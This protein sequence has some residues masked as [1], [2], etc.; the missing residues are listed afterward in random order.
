MLGGFA[1]SGDTLWGAGRFVARTHLGGT[2]LLGEHS[3]GSYRMPGTGPTAV[4]AR[5]MP[6]QLVPRRK[7]SEEADERGCGMTGCGAWAGGAP[8]CY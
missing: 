1:V 2:H 8:G 7:A 6:E 5:Q 3:L 4:R